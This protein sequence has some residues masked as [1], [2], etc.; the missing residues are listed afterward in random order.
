LKK[1]SGAKGLKPADP[2]PKDFY[3]MSD[4]LNGT[5]I[6]ARVNEIDNKWI[7]EGHFAER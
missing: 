5:K 4:S 6:S 1:K 7:Y 3:R 2:D